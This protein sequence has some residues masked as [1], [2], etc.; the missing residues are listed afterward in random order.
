MD[1]QPNRILV[2]DGKNN[3]FEKEYQTPDLKTTDILVKSI[4]TGVC[5]SDI[6]MSQGRFQLLPESMSGHEGLG[7]VLNVGENVKDVKQGDYVATRGEPAYADYYIAK[8]MEYVVVPEAHPRYILEPVACGINVVTQNREALDRKDGGRLAILGSGFL[9]QVAY[10]TLELKGYNYDIDVVGNHNR[11]LWP[12]L[13]QELSGEYDVIIDLSS[14][15]D[16][17]NNA[18]N[19][20]L[21]I[22]ATDKVLNSSIGPLLWRACT[23]S[24]PSPRTPNFYN[25]MIMARDWIESGQLNVDNFWTQAYNRNTQW[26]QAF[27]D[28][29]QRKPGYSRGYISWR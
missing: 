15:T 7:L 9:A 19:N 24:F 27:E 5:R 16:Y 8:Q 23:I 26:Q 21:I 17:F 10:R 6:D 22:L 11:E 28:A 3:W 12:N 25:A 14:R 29:A 18:A 4:Y 20:A 13:K 1:T 2:T